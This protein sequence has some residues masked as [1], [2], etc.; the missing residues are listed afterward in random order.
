M[1][2]RTVLHDELHV[3]ASDVG[4]DNDVLARRVLHESVD[5]VKDVAGV[6]AEFRERSR[7][8]RL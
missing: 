6:D 8:G 5:D 3:V 4:A 2:V 1:R 7:S